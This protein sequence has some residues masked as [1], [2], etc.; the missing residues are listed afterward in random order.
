MKRWMD[1]GRVVVLLLALLGA[2][3]CAQ[4]GVRPDPPRVT[5]VGLQLVDMGLFE[6]HYRLRLRLQNPNDFPLSVAGMQYAL[7]IN[8]QP[9]ATGVSDERIDV[10]PYGSV[11]VEA[12]VFSSLGSVLAQLRRLEQGRL[13][14]LHYRLSGK[15]ALAGRRGKLPFEFQ[16]EVPLQAPERVP[17]S[18]GGY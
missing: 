16:G 4:F 9:F 1:S 2:A 14:R 15:V 3:G 10:K 11:V 12:D 6:Q 17:D 18:P 7:A 13:E 5:L 8:H